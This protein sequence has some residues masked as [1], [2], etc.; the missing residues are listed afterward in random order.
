MSQ[1]GTTLHHTQT[2]YSTQTDLPPP[3][4]GLCR[5]QKTKFKVS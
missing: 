3:F 2:G 1:K 4:L 5:S